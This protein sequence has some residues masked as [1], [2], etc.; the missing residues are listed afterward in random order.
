MG[1]ERLE[2]SLGNRTYPIITGN[3]MLSL[4][5]PTLRQMGVQNRLVIIT[6]SNVAPLYLKPLKHHLTHFGFAPAAVVLSPGESQKSLKTA[7]KVYG[8]LIGSGIGRADAIIAFGGGVIGDLAGFI[9]ATFQR[10]MTMIQLPT[11]LLAQVD[12][13]VG[14]KVAVNHP[15]GKNMIGAFHQPRLVW[16]DTDYLSSLPF[17]EIVCGLGEVVKYGIVGDAELF[18]YIE[19]NLGP[20][21][22]LEPQSITHIQSRC[23]ELKARV[24]SEDEKETGLRMILNCG[25]TI[26]HALEA[27]GKYRL[28]KHGEAVLFGIVAESYIARETGL[29]TD[30]VHRRIVDL[31]ARIPLRNNVQQLKAGEILQFVRRDKK[32]VETRPRFIL[33]IRIGEVKCVDQVDSKLILKSLKYLQ[34]LKLTNR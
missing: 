4:F 33:P 13:S 5:A 34:K 16:C 14:G 32:S 23:L 12:S 29:I 3:G 24:V 2:V 6:D 27:A 25:H 19:R 26:G 28:L 8:E 15:L 17:R 7:G 10:G 1:Q 30:D 21:L 20:V 9:A 22:K 31:I 11:T 18:A